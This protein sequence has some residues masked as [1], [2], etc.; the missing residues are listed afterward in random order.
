M[1]SFDTMRLFFSLLAFGATIVVIGSALL[2]IAAR[3]GTGAAGMRDA[4]LDSVA[5][6]EL[7]L[8]FGVAAVATLGSLYLS[9]IA[10][11]APCKLCWFQ[12]IFMYPLVVVLGVAAWRRDASVRLTTMLLAWIGA[13]IAVYH[14]AIQRYPSLGG[15]SCDASAPC[16]AAYIWQWDFISIPYMAAS[17][18]G[19]ILVLMFALRSNVARMSAP[20]TAEQLT[21]V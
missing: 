16:S 17:A 9:E 14:Y 10:D 7:W 19:L 5:G 20:D 12:R 8:G 6:Y 1:L 18:F 15:G 11:L 4:L 21:D 2:W 13:A 3:V